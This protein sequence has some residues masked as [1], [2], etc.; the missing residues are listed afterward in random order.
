M[1]QLLCCIHN[2]NG[3]ILEECIS[4][5]NGK[6]EYNPNRYVEIV[7]IHWFVLP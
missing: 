2:N 4:L 5:L 7:N 1:P 6:Y 3:N